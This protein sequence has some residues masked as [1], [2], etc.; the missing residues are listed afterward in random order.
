MGTVGNLGA[1]V[2]ILTAITVYS[3][4][5]PLINP[6]EIPQ[7]DDIWWGPKDASQVDTNIKPFKISVPD[8]VSFSLSIHIFLYKN[9]FNSTF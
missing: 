8:D 2:V 5:K 4:I 3:K 7:I 6:P 1:L 9:F